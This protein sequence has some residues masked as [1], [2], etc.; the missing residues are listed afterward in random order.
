[1]KK[2][3]FLGVLL[4]V[5]ALSVFGCGKATSKYVLENL[6]EKTDVYFY[7]EADDF[8]ATL[9]SGEREENYVVD[10]NNTGNV[11]FALL[12]MKIDNFNED[13]LKVDVKIDE[14][15]T[16][17]ELILNHSNS[18]Y[19][20]DLEIKLTGDEKIEIMF[21]NRQVELKNL[22]KDFQIDSNKAIEIASEKLEDKI[23]SCQKGWKLNSECYLRVLDK[24][25]NNFDEM[26][27]CFTVVNIKNENFSIIISTKD[28]SILAQSK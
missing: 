2:K 28:G 17:H 3:I 20:C 5:V 11:K 8:Y 25:A 13:V 18:G 4:S 1:M 21:L 22:S 23:K 16:N 9:S 27:W 10:G 6:S 26:F 7:A 14:N 12:T 19:M 24:R 15:I